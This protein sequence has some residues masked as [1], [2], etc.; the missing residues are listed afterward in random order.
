ML[1]E[2][3]KLLFMILSYNFLLY[4]ISEFLPIDLFPQRAEDILT[5]LAL[6]SALYLAWLFGYREKTVIWLAYLSLFQIFG[7]SILRS[8]YHPIVQFTPSLLTT[9]LLIWL[10]ESPVEKRTKKLEEERKRLEEQL[11]RNEEER[12][13]LLEQIEL[14]REITERLE[15]EKELIEKEYERL[16]EEELTE[17][18]NLEKEREELN[19]KLAETQRRF[20]EYTE[21]LERL[22][23]VNRE[24]FEL[25]DAMQE[26]SPKAGKEELSKLRQERKRLSKELVQLYELLEEL[27]EENHKIREERE[28]L[29]QALAREKEEKELL[30]LEVEQL[31]V[32]WEGKKEAYREVLESVLE[33]IE[34]EERSIREFI[35]LSKEAKQEFIKELMLLNMKGMGERFE[36][37][38]G[39]KNVFKLKPMGG[40]IYFTFGTSKRWK[41]L[42]MLWG[43]EDRLKDRY[44]RELLIKYRD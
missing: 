23:R 18:Q 28:A 39:Y 38:K 36:S 6:N 15:R 31:K 29:L 3:L 26:K 4:Y 34:F 2:H 25:L 41:V 1:G 37:M 33:N 16:R 19:R 7:L 13:R 11:F 5:V 22:T 17:R 24:L 35:E 32:Q 14:L 27:S 40:R 10:F 20:K 12:E 9:V 21:K 8:D 42:G 43:E 44:A 30:K